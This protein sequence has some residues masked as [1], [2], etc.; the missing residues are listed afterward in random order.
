MGVVRVLFVV[1]VMGAEIKGDL[2][3]VC[4]EGVERLGGVLWVRRY[5]QCMLTVG[6]VK[7]GECVMSAGVV[8]VWWI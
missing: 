7:C 6:V 1:G 5:G 3:V 8:C 4:V 2:F